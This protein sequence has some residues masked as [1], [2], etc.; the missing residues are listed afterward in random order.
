M[1]TAYGV[2]LV[3]RA[4]LSARSTPPAELPLAIKRIA[5]T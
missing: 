1:K 4:G 5:A 3:A 2:S